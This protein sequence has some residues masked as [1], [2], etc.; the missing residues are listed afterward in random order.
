MCCKWKKINFHLSCSISLV[1]VL[2]RKLLIYNILVKS[3]LLIPWSEYI[4]AGAPLLRVMN[5]Q[6]AA[7]GQNSAERFATIFKS[8]VRKSSTQNATHRLLML[9]SD[10]YHDESEVQPDDQ[11]GPRTNGLEHASGSGSIHSISRFTYNTNG[12]EH[13]V[14]RFS[15]WNELW[16]I[17]IMS[18]SARKFY[19][20]I[21][22]VRWIIWLDS[23]AVTLH[24]KGIYAILSFICFVKSNTYCR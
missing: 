16:A 3:S 6:I 10:L 15:I 11:K 21:E 22:K 7:S 12:K 9:R 14:F 17:N 4:S 5:L 2:A 1:K 20:W 23:I 13:G 19:V 24:I 8:I 18:F